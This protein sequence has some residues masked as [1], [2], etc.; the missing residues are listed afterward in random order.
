MDPKLTLR[1]WPTEGAVS[2]EDV[3]ALL[4]DAAP[5]LARLEWA[6]SAPADAGAEGEGRL[7]E[8]VLAPGDPDLLL[9]DVRQALGVAKWLALRRPDWWVEVWDD[10]QIVEST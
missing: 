4:A 1:L 8:V 7:L 2:A 10:L 3:E 5:A 6:G 9:R